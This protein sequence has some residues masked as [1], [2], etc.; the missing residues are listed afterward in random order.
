MRLPASLLA[1]GARGPSWAS[2]LDRLPALLR[3]LVAEWELVVDGDPRHGNTAVVFP[4]RTRDRVDAVLKVGFLDAESEHESLAMQ[5]WHGRGAATLLRADPRRG[6]LLLE[7]LTSRDLVEEWDVAACEIVGG[8]YGA[9]HRPA[10]PQLRL[11]SV[12][13]EGWAARLAALPRSAPLPRRMVEQAAHLAASFATDAATDG[14]LLHADLHYE[15]VLADAAGEWRAIDPKPLS[16][17]PHFEPAPL[18]WNRYDEL[19]GDVR[20]GVRR[21]FHAVID[22]AGLDEERARDWVVLRMMVNALWRLEEDAGGVTPAASTG[23]WLTT[24]V[25]VAKAV[26]D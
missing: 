2:W 9:L 17:D 8:L 11:L 20:D 5:H 1:L 15:N 3:D 18:L 16:G 6:A 25:A 14:R 19:A 26:Q 21:R 10:P 12:L 7:R 23:S 22:A 4:V 24:C 13:C